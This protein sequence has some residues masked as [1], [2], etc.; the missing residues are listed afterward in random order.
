MREN[1]ISSNFD[2]FG[3]NLHKS[4]ELKKT[5]SSKISNNKINLLYDEALNNGAI[6]GKLTGAGGGGFLL[7]Y[8][9]KNKQKKLKKALCNLQE[10]DFKFDF[11]G[12]QLLFKT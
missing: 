10:L 8:C 1:L 3:T 2:D 6:G 12:S 11:K 7:L 4:W 9:P 5:F